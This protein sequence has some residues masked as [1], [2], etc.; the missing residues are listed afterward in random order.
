M[1]PS[2]AK[3]EISLVSLTS[4]SPS[5]KRVDQVADESFSA[6]SSSVASV[7]GSGAPQLGVPRP[8]G[9]PAKAGSDLRTPE[10]GLA[11]VGL[12]GA[13]LLS[14]ASPDAQALRNLQHA[15]SH[16][17]EDSINEDSGLGASASGSQAAAKSSG[18]RALPPIASK[19]GRGEKLA[20][21]ENALTQ[22]TNDR[23]EKQAESLSMSGGRDKA[24]SSASVASEISE[25]FISEFGATSPAASLVGP[26]TGG[27]A[28]S[29]GGDTLELSVSA[30]GLGD[31]A[32]FAAAAAAASAEVES[33]YKKDSLARLQADL[34]S[35]MRTLA[36]LRDVRKQQKEFISLLQGVPS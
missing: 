2:G 20:E 1:S 11:G 16:D 21:K 30:S 8:D 15:P 31:S 25:D 4:A 5:P 35:L 26:S 14:A 23:R 9:S 32:H 36:M 7:S 34:S 28:C 22:A 6:E 10:R 29:I 13:G 27:K 17:Q 33:S 12:A 19:A 18:G 3:D 24:C